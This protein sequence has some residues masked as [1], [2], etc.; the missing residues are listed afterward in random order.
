MIQRLRLSVE[1]RM[2]RQ[3]PTL[4]LIRM[5]NWNRKAGRSFLPCGTEVQSDPTGKGKG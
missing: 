3:M 4:Y 2:I 5:A 1:R